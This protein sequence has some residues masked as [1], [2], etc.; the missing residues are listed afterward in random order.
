MGRAEVSLQLLANSI[1]RVITSQLRERCPSENN[2]FSE[3]KLKIYF[4]LQDQQF[5]FCIF[6]FKKFLES[7]AAASP[8][9]SPKEA[10]I[11]LLQVL[12]QFY[13]QETKTVKPSAMNEMGTCTYKTESYE[14]MLSL[15]LFRLRSV[16]EVATLGTRRQ[17]NDC[18][19]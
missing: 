11:W 1:S 7:T 16:I 18:Y 10:E 13:S 8:L 4:G 12:L 6:R 15:K 3:S 2:D 9:S 14:K 19:F 5:R 17:T